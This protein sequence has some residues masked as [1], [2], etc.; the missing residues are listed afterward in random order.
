MWGSGIKVALWHLCFMPEKCYIHW[1]PWE[2]QHMSGISRQS[3]T[4]SQQ[5]KQDKYTTDLPRSNTRRED[6]NQLVVEVVT[7][8]QVANWCIM[9]RHCFAAIPPNRYLH[10][11]RAPHVV[12]KQPCK[13]AGS[14]AGPTLKPSISLAEPCKAWANVVVG[15][16]PKKVAHSCEWMPSGHP[17]LF[18]TLRPHAA[19][20]QNCLPN[21]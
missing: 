10:L 11:P 12:Q 6:S 8:W 15:F 19:L 13:E 14:Q 4:P 3:D 17:A 2:K 21:T 16:Q 1:V 20:T 9:S 7:Q 5:N 18:A